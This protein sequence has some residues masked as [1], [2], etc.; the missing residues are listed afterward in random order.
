MKPIQLPR[1]F[2][3]DKPFMLVW[4]ILRG[5]IDLASVCISSCCTF[6]ANFQEFR[7]I[8]QFLQVKSLHELN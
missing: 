5:Q 8:A 4:D 6:S 7:Y 1:A 2:R 3:P